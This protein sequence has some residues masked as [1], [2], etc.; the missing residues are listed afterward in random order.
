M[1][2]PGTDWHIVGTGDFDGDGKGDL[3]WRTDGGAL[4]I[5]EMTGSQIKAADYIRMGSTAIGAP[6][7]DWHVSG[8]GD[9]DGDGKDDLLWRTDS[10]AL[11][12]WKMDGFQ[13]SAADYRQDRR[14]QCWRAGHRLEYHSAPIRPSLSGAGGRAS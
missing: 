1:K 4:A 12:V 8:T 9:F 6:G 2:A 7:K 5:W 11:A 3:L 13:I 10:G 14:E